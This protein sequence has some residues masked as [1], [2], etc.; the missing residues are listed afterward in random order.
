MSPSRSPPADFPSDKGSSEGALSDAESNISKEFSDAQ[1][2]DPQNDGLR[3]YD[4]PLRIRRLPSP[5]PSA[6]LNANIGRGI[7]SARNLILVEDIK[8]PQIH[9]SNRTMNGAVYSLEQSSN[10]S[11]ALE[12]LQT[13]AVDLKAVDKELG[14][15]GLEKVAVV[16]AHGQEKDRVLKLSPAKIYELTSTPSSLP[17]RVSLSTTQ[18]PLDA[19][20]HVE[21][22]HDNLPMLNSTEYQRD[23]VSNETSQNESRPGSI[24]VTPFSD[25]EDS[26]VTPFS[27]SA[28]RL[29]YVSRP[30]F[31][32]PTVSTHPKK[33]RNLSS[34]S[35]GSK[36]YP[37]AS[38]ST[39][40][41]K[42]SSSTPPPLQLPEANSK[43][44]IASTIE[45][46][47]SPMPQSIPMPPLSL[48]TYLQLEL[49][50]SRPSPLYIH[51][52]A[53]SDFPYESSQ[54]KIERLQNFLLLPFQLEQV[55]W[56]G[57]LA[58]LDAWLFSFTILPLRFVKALSILIYSWGCNLLIEARLLGAFIYSGTGRMWRRR[59]RRDSTHLSAPD[60]AGTEPQR[61]QFSTKEPVSTPIRVPSRSEKLKASRS[62]SH[63]ESDRKKNSSHS[64]KHDRPKS[65][66][67]TLLPDH[68]AD[69]LK[70]FLILISCTILMHFDASRMYHG[71][72]GQAAIKLYV[73]YNV[74]EVSMLRMLSHCY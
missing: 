64:K 69:I 23:S 10:G 54:V 43:I 11:A 31:K 8:K 46:I 14:K 28:G 73:I 44:Q 16:T 33:R 21:K 70:G 3:S 9:R 17:L 45:S 36:Q 48:P 32:S 63:S 39:A 35:N 22:T 61:K 51:R 1:P 13:T 19:E 2:T 65:A 42:F 20:D 4:P 53:T 59:R 7:E 58:C 67:S 25:T 66:P 62:H 30:N 52:S 50:S 26:Q 5:A 72:R 6:A 68:K 41:S 49:S 24:I 27:L 37:A 47:P 34:K 18:S 74:L 29:D 40:P 57:A 56:F 12:S 15:Q 60:P 55:L 38:S 71:I